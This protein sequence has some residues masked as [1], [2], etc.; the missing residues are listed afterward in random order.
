[1]NISKIYVIQHQE[2]PGFWDVYGVAFSKKSDADDF[3]DKISAQFMYESAEASEIRRYL[4]FLPSL[5]CVEDFT[6]QVLETSSS[7]E[8]LHA[9]C[10]S[11]M[12]GGLFSY[13]SIDL[14]HD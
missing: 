12:N 13:E 9:Y 4:G 10:E 6:S 7:K 11:Y 14:H 2:S 8:G 5:N 1:M 3:V